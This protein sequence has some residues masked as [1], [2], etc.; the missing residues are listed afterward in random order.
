MQTRKNFRALALIICTLCYLM[1][2]ATVFDALESETDSRKRTLLAGLEKRFQRKY[3]FTGDDF[4][5]LQ[6]A[7]IRSIPQKAGYQWKFAG[8]FY[9]ATVVI[10]TV[11]YGHSTPTTKLGKTFCMFYALC[12]I[13][14]NLV[15]FQCIGERL[16]AFIAHVLYTVKTS[17]GLRRFQVTHTNMILVSTTMGTV[18]IMLGAYLFHKYEGWTLFDSF[19]YC[20]ITLSTIGFGDYVAIQKNYALERHFEYLMLSLLFILFGLAL[21]SASVNLFVLRFMSSKAE[22]K[23]LHAHP[24]LPILLPKREVTSKAV[25]SNRG[26]QSPL[27]SLI[28]NKFSNRQVTP[29]MD[30]PQ[31]NYVPPRRTLSQTDLKELEAHEMSQLNNITWEPQRPAL[32]PTGHVTELSTRYS[33]SAGQQIWSTM[34]PQPVST[35]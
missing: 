2:G 31:P 24:A 12:G 16:N 18:I 32:G 15:M 28:A 4:R 23:S 3:N 13:P 9:F 30:Q 27:A 17:M 5:V 25:T 8:A 11:G 22:L 21:F 29:S 10:T 1:L 34:C 19:Y 6:T 26:R 35:V 7:V 14:L 33:T 20:F